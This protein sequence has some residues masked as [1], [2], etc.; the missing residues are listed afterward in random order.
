MKDKL[1]KIKQYF[2]NKERI[3]PK[4]SDDMAYGADFD[5]MLCNM[6]NISIEDYISRRMLNSPYVD[7]FEYNDAGI[8]K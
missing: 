1:K 4:W 7:K 6:G 8:N 5:Y 2:D 3:R